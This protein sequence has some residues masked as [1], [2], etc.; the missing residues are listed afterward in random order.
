MDETVD[1]FEDSV[2]DF[3]GEPEEDAVLMFAYG[4]SDFDDGRETAVSRPE[5]P[6][7]EEGLGQ[8]PLNCQLKS[9]STNPKP[10]TKIFAELA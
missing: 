6:L 9:G 2:V 3:G 5:V 4:F 8:R 10:R 7:V 1:D